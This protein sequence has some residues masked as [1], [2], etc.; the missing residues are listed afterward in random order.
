MTYRAVIFDLFG[1]LIPNFSLNEY[2]LTVTRMAFILGVPEAVFWELWSATFTDSILGIL[3]DPQARII[4]LCQKLGM[5]P[6]KEKIE[7]AARLRFEYEAQ[8]MIPR[9]EAVEVLA[10]LKSGDYRIGLITDCSFEA[11][12]IWK[13]TPLAPF[14]GVTVF[15]CLAHIRKPD[16]RI[17][18]LALEQLHVAPGECC[19]IGDGSS[20]ELSGAQNVGLR[21]VQLRIPAEDDPDVYR[22]DREDWQGETIQSL[23]EVPGL[24]GFN[25]QRFKG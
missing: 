20:K 25:V 10:T 16:P 1:T 23:N 14:F 12:A 2:H 8:T 21:A 18:R 4:H 24:V 17:Y 9:P 19:Y 22:V 3:P 5:V 7:E 15:S 6:P 11:A 13:D